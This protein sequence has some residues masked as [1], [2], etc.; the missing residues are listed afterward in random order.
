MP[1]TFEEP[2]KKP[3]RPPEQD[4]AV[5][6]EEPNQPRFNI[7]DYVSFEYFDTPQSRT[8]LKSTGTI[9]SVGTASG[10][11]FYSIQLEGF[12]HKRI[13][14]IPEEDVFPCDRPIKR[15]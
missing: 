14:D 11:Y 1:I 2:R 3:P 5:A 6:E 12:Q 15:K 9:K 8:P 10:K 13:T 4:V 7:G